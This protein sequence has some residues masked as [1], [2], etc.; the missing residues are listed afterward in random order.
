[1]SLCNV[2]LDE[3]ASAGK[4]LIAAKGL[5]ENEVFDEVIFIT[6]KFKS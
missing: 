5:N 3:L 2:T 4:E 1:V 6:K